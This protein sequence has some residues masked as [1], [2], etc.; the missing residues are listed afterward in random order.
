VDAARTLPRPGDGTSPPP[1]YDITVNTTN[2]SALPI[3]CNGAV[4]G[5][6][7]V[8]TQTAITSLRFTAAAGCVIG[9]GGVL[10]RGL[11]AVSSVVPTLV[12][13]DSR[14]VFENADVRGPIRLA[15]TFVENSAILIRNTT[16][17]VPDCSVAT[18]VSNAAAVLGVGMA[19]ATHVVSSTIEVTDSTVSCGPSTF[20]ATLPKSTVG[21]VGVAACS[22]AN[23][24]TVA[25]TNATVT[26]VGG[27]NWTQ[28]SSSSHTLV[29]V[30]GIAAPAH[31]EST[32]AARNSTFRAANVVGINVGCF[33]AG[34]GTAGA[35][36]GN[37]SQIAVTAVDGTSVSTSNVSFSG[38]V[39]NVVGGV[40]IVLDVASVPR[41]K[42][43]ISIALDDASVAVENFRFGAGTVVAVGGVGLAMNFFNLRD[44]NISVAATAVTIRNFASFG[45]AQV[46]GVGAALYTA[47]IVGSLNV[48][49]SRASVIA[50]RDCPR[51]ASQAIGGV[52]TAENAG[53]PA[54]VISIAVS[55]SDVS[56]RDA[57]VTDGVA[58]IGA[59]RYRPATLTGHRVIELRVTHS[60]V[61]VRKGFVHAGM[62]LVHGIGISADS[63]AAENT[64]SI[65]IVA[66]NSSSVVINNTGSSDFSRTTVGALGIAGFSPYITVAN[67]TAINSTLYVSDVGPTAAASFAAVGVCGVAVV[68]VPAVLGGSRWTVSIRGG[69][70]TYERNTFFTAATTNSTKLIRGVGCAAGSFAS[71]RLVGMAI[72]VSGAKVTDVVDGTAAAAPTA[73]G[74]PLIGAAL[75]SS[76]NAT[77]I[78]V[79]GGA[80]LRCVGTCVGLLLFASS[81]VTTAVE[82]AESSLF[83]CTFALPLVMWFS[84]S[85]LSTSAAASSRVALTNTT[86]FVLPPLSLTT[87]VLAPITPTVSGPYGSDAIQP[88]YS[89]TASMTMAFVPT[90]SPTQTTGC[91]STAVSQSTA[92]SASTTM[93]A[94][95][96][97][98]PPMRRQPS[99]T[100]SISNSGDGETDT[101]VPSRATPSSSGGGD[102]SPSRTA[103][104]DTVTEAAIASARRTASVA[105]H[106]PRARTSRTSSYV[107]T[108][109]TSQLHS[110]SAGGLAPRAT[111]SQTASTI[112]KRSVTLLPPV[113]AATATPTLLSPGA[114]NAV[115]GAAN[116]AAAVVSVI[117]AMPGVAAQVAMA[118]AA[119]TMAECTHAVPE[120]P[121]TF[122]QSLA[123]GLSVGRPRA[124]HYRGAMVAS[125]AS[126]AIGG[127]FL[128]AAGYV[129]QRVRPQMAEGETGVFLRSLT[130]VM[131]PGTMFTVVA[132]NV[133]PVVGAATA[134]LQVGEDYAVDAP[135]AVCGTAFF[136]FCV[137][138][139]WRA[140]RLA[141]DPSHATW[142]LRFDPAAR[143]VPPFKRPPFGLSCLT[144]A[145]LRWCFYGAG[146]WV[147]AI[148]SA[149][150]AAGSAADATWRPPSVSAAGRRLRVAIGALR[151]D[152]L[153][154][155]VNHDDGGL[156]AKVIFEPSQATLARRPRLSKL[157]P[158]TQEHAVQYKFVDA[159][160]IPQ[161]FN[162][163]WQQADTCFFF[164]F[165]PSIKDY[166]IKTSFSERKIYF[167]KIRC[168]VVLLIQAPR[169]GLLSPASVRA[170]A[171]FGSFVRSLYA[172]LSIRGCTRCH[173]GRPAA[174]STT[175][176]HS[177]PCS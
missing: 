160:R 15:A 16:V 99:R 39:G 5:I 84:S 58:G 29:G 159:R 74:C 36:V 75:G 28:A 162:T 106:P 132:F 37:A 165:S 112:Y 127:A 48:A 122:P 41:V 156:H 143:V 57:W 81:F 147:D 72:S 70:V 170:F 14:L 144:P 123:P 151:N 175:A 95:L 9:I 76:P 45:Y 82:V 103:N 126:F 60:T 32:V 27:F 142:C 53:S 114:V 30:A 33:V 91:V 40:G 140:V 34:V 78:A 69:S 146:A 68:S 21:V 145:V 77:E 110:R 46:D 166:V 98:R 154:Q 54:A 47:V 79:L 1:T 152:F 61:D 44:A 4:T 3:V 153:D 136:T 43:S 128:L 129:L 149:E 176:V 157:Q 55:D 115:S 65:F 94:S 88:C 25:F 135:V 71:G 49:V 93:T 24:V 133:D 26:S 158:A 20:S 172:Y 11:S 67:I 148:S 7:F 102:D 109:N 89:H 80:V 107:V 59:V 10:F 12:V 96:T 118:Q 31:I 173:I 167:H 6:N 169:E 164:F 64:T 83:Q 150:D 119:M 85:A 171:R 120:T 116:G 17:A 50:I 87:A 131:A 73:A 42:P 2:G 104:R 19:S 141:T 105:A 52:G 90:M 86:A 8:P 56:L 125:V 63:N 108:W 22:T 38:V 23:A 117:G 174:R 155:A 51:S 92:V 35:S 62:S 161:A 177:H 138:Y 168:V 121:L 101:P 13:M 137:V 139:M 163:P 113:V 18:D 100:G 111:A 130:A 134:L 66:V 97:L 124:G